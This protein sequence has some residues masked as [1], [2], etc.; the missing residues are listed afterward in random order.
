MWQLAAAAVTGFI[1]KEE[2]VGTLG[3][4]FTAISI[5][6]D[7]NLLQTGGGEEIL[8]ITASAGL[9]Y[10]MFNLFSPPCFAAIGAMNSE[11]KSKKWLFAGIGLQISL[12]YTI[13]F[14]VYQIGTMITTGTLGVAFV[15]GLITILAIVSLFVV[16]G[17]SS[18]EKAQEKVSVR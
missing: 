6:E 4:I 1:A 7:F 13:S 9:A 15:P 10:L 3:A 16:I 5:D 17:L 14:F 2:V 8:G 18:R 11:I 12:A